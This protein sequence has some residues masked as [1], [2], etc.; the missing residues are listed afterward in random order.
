M[1]RWINFYQHLHPISSGK[2]QMVPSV[3]FYLVLMKGS[4]VFITHSAL[5]ESSVVGTKCVGLSH[6]QRMFNFRS[7]GNN[8]LEHL[9]IYSPWSVVHRNR[10]IRN[11]ERVYFFLVCLGFLL[12][13][14]D[15]AQ[16]HLSVILGLE[17]GLLYSFGQLLSLPISR[18]V[19]T[20]EFNE[21]NH[22]H[23]IF[24]T[25]IVC[26]ALQYVS[27]MCYFK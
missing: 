11:M 4:L 17:I 1:K 27:Y 14:L 10:N 20:W 3:Q 24:W 15:L 18:W 25:L 5:V 22:H 26:Q 12:F 7:Y 2:V 21:N 6:L 23:I 9:L 13:L 19:K 16:P 8:G